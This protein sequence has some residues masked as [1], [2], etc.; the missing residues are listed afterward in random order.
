MRTLLIACLSLSVILT[1]KTSHAECTEYQII[2]HGDSVEAVCVG[3][4]LT[5]AEKKELEKDKAHGGLMNA[6]EQSRAYNT[7][8]TAKGI[9]RI[10]QIAN[11]AVKSEHAYKKPLRDAQISNLRS[12]TGSTANINSVDTAKHGVTYQTCMSD[13]S[14]QQMRCN[15][16]PIHIGD[17]Q[18]VANCGAMKGLCEARC[19]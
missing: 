19:N 11:D 1:T 10:S 7:A 3:K 18:G 15:V 5:A 17:V 8:E 4:P 2:D 16:Q 14:N 13:C 12:Q 6:I 9:N